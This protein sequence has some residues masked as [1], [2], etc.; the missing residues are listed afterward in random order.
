MPPFPKHQCWSTCND[1]TPFPGAKAMLTCCARADL[2]Y[3]K[4]W[5]NVSLTCVVFFVLTV[6]ETVLKTMLLR[7]IWEAGFWAIVLSL[8]QIKLFS[9]PIIGYW[10]LSS[11][12]L[13]IAGRISEKPLWGHPESALDWH[14]VTKR[15]NGPCH[16]TAPFSA[17]V[18]S[19]WHLC[20]L[21]LSDGALLVSELHVKTW[22]L[23]GALVYFLGE[24]NLV[25][26]GGIPW[27]G[28][29]GGLCATP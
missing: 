1:K 11:T 12:L 22:S 27:A 6:H 24:E 4:P 25:L 19:S 10:L 23:K 9:I 8:P 15:W 13:G 14:L 17:S 28:N 18:S 3:S 2:V 26:G 5:R 7:V 16:F 20:L 21:V 29:P